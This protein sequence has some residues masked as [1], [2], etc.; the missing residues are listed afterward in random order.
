MPWRHLQPNVL[1][2]LCSVLGVLISASVLVRLLQ[3]LRPQKDFSEVRLR[4][5]TWWVMAGL[6]VAALVLSNDFAL[7]FF[8]FVSFLALKEYLSLT[9]TRRADRR[10]LFW[11]YL[12]IPLQYYWISLGWYGMFIVFIPVIMFLCLPMRMV[13]IGETSG[14]LHA[15][16][17]LHWGLMV[18]VFCLSHVAYLLVLPEKGNPVGGGAGLVLFLVALT[19]L[20]DVAQFCWGKPF[21]RN[22]VLPTVSPNKS[23]EGLF[24]G[25]ATTI[26]LAVLLAPYLTPL[27]LRESLTAGLLIGMGGFMG[28]VMVAAL[29]RDL[30]IKDSGNI[31]PG[32]GGILD[33]VNSLTCTAPLFFHFIYYLHY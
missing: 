15:I 14:Y 24:G 22:K 7:S 8:G 18:T 28:D 23:Y 20:N 11:A 13:L 5:R 10:V 2:G 29:K 30:G 12:A 33:R 27:N 16:G 31:L 25:L 19:Q 3:V 9:A 32:H 1:I 21:G 17:T 6:F 4:V 26:A